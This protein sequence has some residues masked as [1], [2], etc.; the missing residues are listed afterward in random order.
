MSEPLRGKDLDRE[1]RKYGV[2][3]R[4]FGLESD[5]HLRNRLRDAVLRELTR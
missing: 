5:Y 3:R 1:A 4:W 2:K